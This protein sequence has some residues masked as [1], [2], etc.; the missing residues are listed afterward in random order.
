MACACCMVTQLI[1]SQQPVAALIAFRCPP[2]ASHH[3]VKSGCT[4]HTVGGLQSQPAFVGGG[5]AAAPVGHGLRA[6]QHA[7]QGQA[8]LSAHRQRAG[9]RAAMARQRPGG[10]VAAA[11]GYI[12]TAEVFAPSC[13]HFICTKSIRP[14]LTF[15]CNCIQTILCMLRSPAALANSAA[16]SISVC[17]VEVV[18]NWQEPTSVGLGLSIECA[19]PGPTP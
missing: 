6:G 15:L 13:S 12:C 10:W 4:C 19:L 3:S 8:G 7:A 2:Y 5:S 9:P 18:L 17:A 16:G 11:S 14:A 1:C